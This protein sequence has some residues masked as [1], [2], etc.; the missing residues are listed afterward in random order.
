[1]CCADKMAQVDGI[2]DLKLEKRAEKRGKTV[3]RVVHRLPEAIL[4]HLL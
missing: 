4:L 2:L 3:G 1:V